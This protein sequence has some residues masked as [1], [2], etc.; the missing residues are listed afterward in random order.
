M[1]VIDKT[2]EAALIPMK[3]LTFSCLHHHQHLLLFLLIHKV[4]A[5]TIIKRHS[6]TAY[7]S[8]RKLR[9]LQFS[10]SPVPLLRSFLF[11]V[12]HVLFLFIDRKLCI[13][14]ASAKVPNI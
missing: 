12:E 4:F 1:E 7:F 2:V 10:T 9:L 6:I 5:S 8:A 11:L 13:D 14:G 3:A